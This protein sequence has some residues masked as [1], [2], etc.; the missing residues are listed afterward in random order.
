MLNTA[1]TNRRLLRYLWS[2]FHPGLP[3]DRLDG[4]DYYDMVDEF[5][6]A[7]FLRWPDVVVQ[8]EDFAT[9]KA[10]PLLAKSVRV[11]T[12]CTVQ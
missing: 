12:A 10:V 1:R 6:R 11:H 7:V 5:M 9:P 8:F 4:E 2:T 3:E